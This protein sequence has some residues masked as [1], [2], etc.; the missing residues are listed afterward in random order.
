M[1]RNWSL[2]HSA[3]CPFAVP[4]AIGVGGNISARTR[5]TTPKPCEPVPR[6]EDTWFTFPAKATTRHVVTGR[7][8]VPGAGSWNARTPGRTALAAC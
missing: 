3:I 8:L 1:T 6:V 4:A 5:A 7:T 2:K